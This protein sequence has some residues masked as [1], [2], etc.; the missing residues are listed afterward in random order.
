MSGGFECGNPTGD[1]LDALGRT[2]RR[3]AEFLDDQRHSCL[4]KRH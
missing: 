1:A 4:K 2:H 3:L